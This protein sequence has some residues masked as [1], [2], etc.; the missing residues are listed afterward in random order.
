MTVGEFVEQCG[1]YID[2]DRRLHMSCVSDGTILFLVEMLEAL[3]I[4]GATD[5]E[6]YTEYLD[7]LPDPERPY[8]TCRFCASGILPA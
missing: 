1:G 6:Y 5:I 3:D 4:L 7:K 2:K 8:L